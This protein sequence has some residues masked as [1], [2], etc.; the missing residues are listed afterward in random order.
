MDRRVVIGLVGI[1]LA[2]VAETS[3]AQTTPARDPS[4]QYP[5]G[6]APIQSIGDSINNTTLLSPGVPV[7][8]SAVPAN[9]VGMGPDAALPRVPIPLSPVSMTPME[10]IQH[11]INRGFGSGLFSSM[12]RKSADRPAAAILRTPP[13]VEPASKFDSSAIPSIW[14]DPPITQPASGRPAPFAGRVPE[15]PRAQADPRTR[16]SADQPAGRP[17]PYADDRPKAARPQITTTNTPS[18]RPNAIPSTNPE[19]VVAASA[20]DSPVEARLPAPEPPTPLSPEPLLPAP[21]VIEPPS[22]VPVGQDPLPGLEPVAAQPPPLIDAR[23]PVESAPAPSPLPS[24]V[25]TPSTG[26]VDAEVNRTSLDASALRTNPVPARKLANAAIRAASVGDEIITFNELQIA[27]KEKMRGIPENKKAEMAPS[28]FRQLENHAAAATLNE[29][30]DRALILQEAK[31]KLK[32]NPK[33]KQ[34]FDE[35]TESQWKAEELPMLLRNTATSNVHELKIKLASEGKSYESLKEEFRKKKLFHE[36]LGVE[37]RNKATTDMIEMRR[38]Y[39]EHLDKFEQ[40]ERM[41]WREIEINVARYP[42]R[43]AARQKA[44]EVLARLLHDEDFDAVARSVSNGPTASKGGVYVDMQPGGYGISIVNDERQRIPT[45]QVSQILEAPSSFHIIRVDSRREKGPLRFD[46]VQEKVRGMVYSQN[47]EKAVVD[48]LA[49][50]RA[51]T[52]IRTMFDNTES[53]PELARRNTTG[54]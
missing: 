39:T 5:V 48:H 44:E 15:V 30:I 3:H 4:G 6:M 12:F 42:S 26:P 32:K 19:P 36:F 53:D 18:Y 9:P 20:P 51:R 49:K 47:F 28:E 45:G 8:S 33:L 16:A 40:P 41:T 38:Y 25:L 10:P 43:A 13:R 37:I 52:L 50:L 29:L 1:A 23:V 22:T 7:V 24:A 31:E 21:P 11:S 14:S 54:R 17:A 35:F 27:V 2:G 34:A 46:E